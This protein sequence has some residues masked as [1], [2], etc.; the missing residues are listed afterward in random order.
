M[1]IDHSAFQALLILKDK[2]R[3]DDEEARKIAIRY[4]EDSLEYCKNSAN[5]KK[6][7][8]LEMATESKRTKFKLIARVN[9]GGLE[10]ME[11]C[12]DIYNFDGMCSSIE[13]IKS[14]KSGRYM[15]RTYSLEELPDVIDNALSWYN[16][17]KK[18]HH[19]FNST[20]LHILAVDDVE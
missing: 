11:W 7:W 19:S 15:K 9:T 13:A 12:D 14:A 8:L 16:S 5:Q 17:A 10:L 4:I 1:N 3:F 20:M 2:E 6:D 18:N